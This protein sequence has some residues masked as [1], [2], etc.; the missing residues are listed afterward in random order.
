MAETV[1]VTGRIVNAEDYP[2]VKVFII[3]WD[4]EQ[5]RIHR[6]DYSEVVGV[7]VFGFFVKESENLYVMAWSDTNGNDRFDRG[8][9]AWISH[10]ETGAL[11]PIVVVPDRPDVLASLSEAFRY[12]EELVAPAEAFYRGRHRSEARS[13]WEIPLALGEVA[14][15]SEDRFSSAG[16]S[17]GYWEP[18]GYAMSAGLGIYFTE[19][20][21]PGRVPVLFVHGAAG[22]PHDFASMMQ[23]FDR[24][25]FQLW[26]FHYPSGRR[27]AEMGGGLDHGLQILR[28]HYGFEK[29]HLVAHSMGGLVSRYAILEN[30]KAE[31]PCVGRFV[32]ISSP[33]GGQEFAAKGVRHAPSVVPSWRDIEPGSV[34][35][36][37]L[38]DERFSREIDHLMLYGDRSEERLGLPDENDGTVSVASMTHRPAVREAERLQCFHDDHMAILSNPVVIREVEEFLRAAD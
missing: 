18:A 26:F 15:V 25:R 37:Q 28:A 29:V 12:P 14:Q 5:G 27:L 8:E 2:A 7:G 23:K 33:F 13:G 9:P 11:A 16:A 24:G 3:D 1:V 4:R 20:Y 10:D 22:S 6:M 17:A 19:P 30:Q 32:S 21:D 36:T 31:D 38:F 35:L 34:F